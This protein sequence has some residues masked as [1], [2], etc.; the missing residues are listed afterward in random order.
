MEVL[1]DSQTRLG[2]TTIALWSRMFAMVLQF[3]VGGLIA[4][5]HMEVII[6][7]LDLN[8]KLAGPCSPAT[9]LPPT[10]D[11]VWYCIPRP[12]GCPKHLAGRVTS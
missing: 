8:I 5:D 2:F 11:V 12:V 1:W 7:A 4:L 10:L 3:V 9:I 6:C